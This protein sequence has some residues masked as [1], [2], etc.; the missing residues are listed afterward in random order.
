MSRIHRFAIE[1]E[2]D[3]GAYFPEDFTWLS[4]PSLLLL[5]AHLG[6]EHRMIKALFPQE[7]VVSSGFDGDSA[8]HDGD[9][10][11]VADGRQFV[12]DDQRRHPFLL[13]KSPQILQN[14]RFRISV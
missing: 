11:R 4:F 13:A 2:N 8:L 14:A 6:M 3:D 1:R 7:L 10:V 12:G 5:D 9:A